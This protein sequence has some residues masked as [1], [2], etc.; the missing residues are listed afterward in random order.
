MPS[1]PR[2]LPH[3]WPRQEAPILS[4]FPI[5]SDV[6]PISASTDNQ[7]CF[8]LILTGIAFPAIKHALGPKQPNISVKK[9]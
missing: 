6:P 3:P 2:P 4:L 1:L 7:K 8:E 9:V 5:L